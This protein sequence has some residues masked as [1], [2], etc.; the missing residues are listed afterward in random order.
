MALLDEYYNKQ[1]KNLEELYGKQQ[2]NLTAE[3]Q[4]QL[5]Q[6]AVAQRLREKYLPNLLSAYGVGNT[7]MAQSTYLDLQNLY[8]TQRGNI[9]QA[10]QTAL[11]GLE[12]NYMTNLSNLEREQYQTQ[13]TQQQQLYDDLSQYIAMAESKQQAQSLL[14]RYKETLS[15]TQYKMLQDQIGLQ[16]YG[17]TDSVGIPGITPER[18]TRFTS[19]ISEPSGIQNKKGDN[20]S[21]SVGS[22]SFTNLELGSNA[23]KEVVSAVKAKVSGGLPIYTLFISSVDNNV[24]VVLSDGSIKRVGGTGGWFKVDSEGKDKGYTNYSSL[25]ALLERRGQII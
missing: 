3:K 5:Q 16:G 7:G 20:F 17:D 6:A 14:D 12:S 8:G 11:S 1:K 19:W 18:D 15:E 22:T 23:S 24:Y 25:K 13:L 4:S 10:Y 9:G 2:A 21:V